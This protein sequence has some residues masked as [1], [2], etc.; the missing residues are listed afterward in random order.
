[1]NIASTIQI[2]RISQVNH[3]MT[4]TNKATK[5][6]IHFYILIIDLF[7]AFCS[8]SSFEVTASRNL[9]EGA[10]EHSEISI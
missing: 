3:T 6:Q 5:F 9:N 1:M 7:L 8:A 2:L 10:T 4:K